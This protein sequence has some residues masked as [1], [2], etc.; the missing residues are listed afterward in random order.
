MQSKM[1]WH[2]LPSTCFSHNL[3]NKYRC[4]RVGMQTNQKGRITKKKKG[5]MIGQLVGSWLG[6]G[7][8]MH[9]KL[10]NEMPHC[11]HFL[12][13]SR[14]TH[15]AIWHGNVERIQLLLCYFILTIF[16][17]WLRI[18]WA[19]KMRRLSCNFSANRPTQYILQSE[20]QFICS[21]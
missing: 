9:F 14:A 18:M 2:Q 13:G 6:V 16:T 7:I 20:R 12:F 5:N 1:F 21:H 10:I 17:L 15:F 4:I 3:L 8:V 19:V 11:L